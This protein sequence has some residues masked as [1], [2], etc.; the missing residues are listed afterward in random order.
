MK[1]DNKNSLRKSCRIS[2]AT[3]L[4]ALLFNSLDATTQGRI[5]LQSVY[6]FKDIEVPLRLYIEHFESFSSDGSQFGFVY[7]PLMKG[8]KRDLNVC[9]FNPVS[10]RMNKL[11]NHALEGMELATT[12]R[13]THNH[14]VQPWNRA[15]ATLDDNSWLLRLDGQTLKQANSKGHSVTEMHICASPK[16]VYG[17]VCYPYTHQ[18]LSSGVY[19]WHAE[20]GR[21][22]SVQIPRSH[23]YI[24]HLQADNSWSALLNDSLCVLTDITKYKIWVVGP[25]GDAKLMSVRQPEG[26]IQYP[27]SLEWRFEFYSFMHGTRNAWDTLGEWLNRFS[28]IEKVLANGVGDVGVRYTALDGGKLKKFIAMYRFEGDSLKFRNKLTIDGWS[29]EIRKVTQENFSSVYLGSGYPTFLMNDCSLIALD[30]V[31]DGKTLLGLKNEKQISAY[32]AAYL[33]KKKT[34]AVYVYRFD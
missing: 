1:S 26:W 17:H 32:Q 22:D 23:L 19:R 11:T 4:F 27:D 31:P 6:V 13:Q 12:L 15:F 10:G 20:M 2:A 18:G 29:N 30:V 5:K 28:R 9:S 16:L 33:V 21:I 7:K 25:E 34:M 3:F 8:K 14:T 24:T